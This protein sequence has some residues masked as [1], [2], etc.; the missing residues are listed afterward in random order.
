MP[1]IEGFVVAVPAKNKEVYRKHVAEAAPLFKKL[2]ATRL[3][4]TWEDDVPTGEVT[5]FRKAVEAKPDEAIVFSWI[6]Y[7]DRATRDAA[8]SKMQSDPS[9]MQSAE[10]MP[11]DGMRMIFGG[12]EP[13]VVEGAGKGSYVDGIVVPVRDENKDAYRKFAKQTAALFRDYGALSVAETWADDVPE[14]KV[15]DFYRAIKA[16][17][18]EK[19]CFSWIVWPDKATRNKAWESCMNDPRMQPEGGAIPYDQKRMF[20]GGFEPIFDE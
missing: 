7:P 8:N 14:G 5:D 11:F 17:P 19:M 12:F 20:W 9:L 1:Y 2:G 13:I 3:V 4:E 6:E 10:P 16:E 15:T 18:G